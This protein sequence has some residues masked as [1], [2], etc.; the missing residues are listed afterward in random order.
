MA[1]PPVQYEFGKQSLHELS[2]ITVH[3]AVR[4]L[5]ATQTVQLLAVIPSQ[6]VEPGTQFVMLEPP[7]QADDILQVMHVPGSLEPCVVE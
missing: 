2:L 5:P 4:Y 7:G 3:G 1:V 6:Y